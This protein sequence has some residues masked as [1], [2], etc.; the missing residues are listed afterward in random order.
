MALTYKNLY[1]LVDEQ[2]KKH[3]HFNADQQYEGQAG[4]TDIQPYT[5]ASKSTSDTSVHELVNAL[6]TILTDALGSRIV[7][8]LTVVADD[9]PNDTITI[10]AGTG[11]VGG[12][13]YSLAEDTVLT[14][15]FEG[16]AQ[17]YYVNLYKNT[18]LLD[19]TKD[20]SKLTIAKIVVPKPSIADRVRDRD[21]GS[22]DAYIVQFQEYKFYGDAWGN[23]EEDS[24][25]VLRNNMG[26]ILAETIVGTL[27]VSDQLQV[28]NI[29][30]TVEI[31]SESLKIMNFNEDVM[32][33]FNKNGVFFYRADGVELAKFAESGAKIGNIEINPTDIR[34]TN[35]VE[36]VSGFRIQDDGNVEFNQLVVRGTVYASRG[37]IGGW[38]IGPTSLY[39]TDTGTIKTG[40]NVAAGQNGVILDTA[41]LRGYSATL[42]TVFNLPTDGSSPTFSAGVIE[43]TE[44]KIST[45]GIIRTSDTVGDGSA[46]SAGVLINDTGLYGCAADQLAA[47]ANFKILIDGS[48]YLKGEIQATSGSIGGITITENQLSG[49]TIVGSVIR[50][51]S[52]ETSATL[53]K[54]RIDATG[55]TYQ[56]S[57]NTGKYARFKY[58]DGTDY[59][60][61]VLGYLFNENYPILSVMAEH[62]KADVRFYNRST[63]PGPGTGSHIVGDIVCV[64]GQLKMCRQDGNPGT[65]ADIFQEGK[66][67]ADLILEK[68]TSDPIGPDTGRLWMR[69]DI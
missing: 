4:R 50:G 53:P 33:K 48:A 24:L 32:A 43:F 66:E 29:K 69:T 20:S 38:T 60:S 52:I 18:I 21:D 68:R 26:D 62:D 10:A 30:G 22:D 63:N 59:G 61:G 2:I 56:I 57:G 17:C 3:T 36:G 40:A 11:T 12:H 5:M 39:A 31:D 51:A 14:L 34:S 16:V 28:K 23:L 7:S 25:E 9:P 54:V 37:E 65:F 64:Q 49:G 15:P 67:T 58:G 42:G 27:L 47:E 8:G 46:D 6:Q 1:T 41:G 45:S 13:V 35:W 55:V 19:R 44:F